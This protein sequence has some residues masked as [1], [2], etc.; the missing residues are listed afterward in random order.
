MPVR[1]ARNSDN[2]DWV[3]IV[4]E[5]DQA[6]FDYREGS[7]TVEQLGDALLALAE[8]NNIAATYIYGRE[9]Q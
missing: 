8:H 2:K 1:K 6:L 5:V 4:D 3:L 9:T 7:A